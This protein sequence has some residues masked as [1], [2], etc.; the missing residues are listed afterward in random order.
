MEAWGRSRGLELEPSLEALRENLE[1]LHR[2][3]A[4]LAERLTPDAAP[5]PEGPVAPPE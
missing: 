1:S 4:A 2:R 5:P 3:L